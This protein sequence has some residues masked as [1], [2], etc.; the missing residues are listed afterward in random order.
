MNF[1]DILKERIHHDLGFDFYRKEGYPYSKFKIIFKESA[2]IAGTIFVPTIV[3]IV[4]EEF[5]LEEFEESKKY[6]FEILKR[7]GE[8][9]SSKETI[10]YVYANANVLLKAERTICNILSEL[11]GIATHVKEILSKINTSVFLLDTRKNDPLFRPEHKYAIRLAGGKNHRS[12]FFDGI[13]IKDNDIAIFGS[14]KSA[15]DNS[16]KNSKF[17]TKIEIE[18]GNIQDLETVLSDGRVDAILLDNMSV[19]DLKR[20]VEIISQSKKHYLVEASGVR[21][22]DVKEVSKTGVEFISMSSLIRRA[23]YIDVSMKVDE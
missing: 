8:Q 7:D 20:A 18:V 9:V 21:E 13:L 3:K 23:R 22:E 11:S 19:K 16:L 10:M 5:F 12:G 17:L 6:K 2:T 1:K 14:I 15:I 4:E